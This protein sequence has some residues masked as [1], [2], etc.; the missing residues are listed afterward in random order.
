[1]RKFSMRY[2]GP[3]DESRSEIGALGLAISSY[4]RKHTSEQAVS[5][6]SVDSQVEG[7]GPGQRLIRVRYERKPPLDNIVHAIEIADPVDEERLER[8]IKSVYE[9]YKF[10]VV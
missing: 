2:T 9:I 7:R 3:L 6:R 5:I 8:E 1:M 10:S 4:F